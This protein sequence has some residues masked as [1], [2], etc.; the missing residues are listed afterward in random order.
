TT[1][2]HA[3]PCNRGGATQWVP[4]APAAHRA[5]ARIGCRLNCGARAS[6]PCYDC[7][8]SQ[9]G[10]AVAPL[11]DLASSLPKASQFL[12]ARGDIAH[13]G[14]H[15]LQGSILGAQ[16]HDGELQR[17]PLAILAQAWNGKEVAL[18]VATLP[19]S[20]HLVVPVPV[21]LTQGFRNN[22]VKRL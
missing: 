2:R 14:A 5:R 11:A 7:A 10:P 1:W 12:K 13:D 17:N 6:P 8:G 18:P 4:C 15:P 19:R 16:W 21:S 20:H 3:N 9:R 22:Q